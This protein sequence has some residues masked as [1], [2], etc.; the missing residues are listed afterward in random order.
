MTTTSKPKT[1]EAATAAA[2]TSAT[3]K[4]ADMMGEFFTRGKANEGLQLPLYLPTGLKSD[5]WVRV[6]GI[7]SDVFRVAE[8]ES[9]RDAF[10]V[11][12]IENEAERTAAMTTSKVKLIASLI[13]EWSFDKPCTQANVMAFLTEAP[14]IMDA[15]DLAASK[16]ALFFAEK[17][18]S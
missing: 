6:L 1:G 15:V 5:Q 7:D 14:Q 18:N 10:R 13:S 16:R 11:A 8:S 9:R 12:T 4:P 2:P 17:S 3:Q